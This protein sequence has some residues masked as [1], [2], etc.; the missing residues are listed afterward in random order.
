MYGGAL[1]I[2][3]VAGCAHEETASMEASPAPE[4]QAQAPQQPAER[5]PVAGHDIEAQPGMQLKQQGTYDIKRGEFRSPQ[6][7][8]LH[9]QG[10][11]GTKGQVTTEGQ[12]MEKG[13]FGTW[14]KSEGTYQRPTGVETQAEGTFF[15]PFGSTETSERQPV[16]GHD[17]TGAFVLL[18]GDDGHIY[19]VSNPSVLA[20][21]RQK[22]VAQGCDPGKGDQPL[23][24]G[25]IRY[26]QKMGMTGSGVLDRDTAMKL[27][28]DWDSLKLK[29]LKGQ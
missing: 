25:V 28:L 7:E 13:S 26:Q 20:D 21:V 14:S 3:A 23:S 15:K 24:T 22:L 17:V 18:R 1:C 19:Q 4:A 11:Y 9:P 10:I 12:V 29:A 27:G 6:G 16:A 2:A 5:Q 8:Y